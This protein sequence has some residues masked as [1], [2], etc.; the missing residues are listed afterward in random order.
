MKRLLWSVLL[1][2]LSFNAL[3]QMEGEDDA[4]SD[5]QPSPWGIGIAAAI[6]DSPYAGE[7]TRIVPIPLIS[8][9]GERFYFRGL[10]TGWTF[11]DEWGLELSAVAKFRLDGVNVDDL[12]RTA[13]SRNGLDYRLL[14]DRDNGLDAG[15]RGTWG[16]RAG[17]LEVEL[18]SDV[19]GT[20]GGQEVSVQYGYP[21]VLWEGILTPG[22]GA[23]WLSEDTANY[24]YGT[25]DEEV[26]R[27]VV[28]Y[29]PGSVTIPSITLSYFKPI[30]EKWSLMAMV[31]YS[32]LPDE[33]KN[34]PLIDPDT[35]GTASMFIGFSR[36]FDF[37]WMSDR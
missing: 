31:D 28:E 26:A 32:I 15:L 36:G 17:E 13:L 34:S 16:G 30:G 25:L 14:E 3:A 27:G 24:Y 37:W 8:Y 35:D 22:V 5:Q 12:D 10:T 9:E 2:G 11:L 29:R 19:S 6:V 1:C 21:I 20:S 18:L 7:G 23:K 33:I 4:S